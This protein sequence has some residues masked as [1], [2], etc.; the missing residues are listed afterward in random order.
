MLAGM[1]RRL[2][3]PDAWMSGMHTAAGDAHPPPR[4]QP[5]LCSYKSWSVPTPSLSATTTAHPNHPSP[6]P[7]QQQQQQQQQH[8]HPSVSFILALSPLLPIAI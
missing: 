7:K 3:V 8:L 2:M 4:H 1:L 5:A 6:S